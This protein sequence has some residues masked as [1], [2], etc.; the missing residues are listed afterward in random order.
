MD[1]VEHIEAL[2]LEGDRM[3][4]AAGAAEPGR[5]RPD[6]P[7]VGRARPGAPHRRGAPLG[8]RGGGHAPDRGRGPWGSTRWSAPGPPT[9]SWSGGSGRVM[10]AWWPRSRPPRPTSSAGPSCG[11]PRP[12]PTGPA[13][14]PTR[15]PSIGSTPSWPPVSALSPVDAAVAADGVD[16]LLC[17]F[18]PRR[19]TRLRAETPT[20]LRVRST[21]TGER[22]AAADR[23]RRGLVDTGGG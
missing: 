14:R 16:E 4:E 7:R 17:G 19:S 3:A 13:G 20:T 21:D 6:V 5:T 10:P 2:R 11:P 18:V 8:H 23:R 15:R 1:V 9:T 12:W 22:L